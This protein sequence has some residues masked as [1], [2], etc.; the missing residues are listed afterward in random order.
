MDDVIKE[1]KQRV[2]MCI[3][4]NFGTSEQTAERDAFTAEFVAK[5]GNVMVKALELAEETERMYEA[6]TECTDPEWEQAIDN[7]AAAKEMR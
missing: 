2:E 5:H 3:L 7:Y 4:R 1:L 6:R